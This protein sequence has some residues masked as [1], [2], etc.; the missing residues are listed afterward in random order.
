MTRLLQLYHRMPSFLRAAVASARGLQLQRYRY[1]P[2]LET[3]IAEAL[4]RETWDAASW[5]AWTEKHLRRLLVRAAT[6][7]PY[8]REQWARRRREGDTASWE[9][10]ANWPILPKRALKADQQSFLAD[11]R[12]PSRMDTIHTSGTTGT[13]LTMRASRESVRGWYTLIEAR[14]RRWYGV[15]KD[16]RWAMI[17]GQLVTPYRQTRPPFWV[18]NAGM[19]QLY[20]SSY[21]LSPERASAYLDALRKYRIV[22]I[23]GYASSL[24]SLAQFALEQ[25]LAAVPMKAAVSNAEPLLAYQR[26][27]IQA[28]FQCP[29]YDLYGMCERVCAASECPQGRMHL[30]PEVGHVEVVTDQADV[31][32]PDGEVGRLICTGLLNTDM[33]LIRYA[34]GDCG[35]LEPGDRSCACGR[36]LPM[37]KRI[38][39]RID[40]VLVTPDGRR[41]GRLDPV[42]KGDLPI[43]EAQ[44]IQEDRSRIRVRLVPSE[45]FSEATAG[46][47]LD[48]IRDRVGDMA[49]EIEIVDEIPR[50]ARGKFRAVINRMDRS[51]R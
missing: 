14:T 37:I 26:E 20:L 39:G 44:I 34:L 43:R 50:D 19:N 21:H 17:G 7:V 16:D 49:L 42:F 35:A 5:K 23:L 25:G 15:T 13:P 51:G 22:H 6:R 45:G 3:S 33:P 32:V 36:T 10:L 30:W 48:R 11:D 38:E 9:E 27:P 8:Y 2:N 31:P 4:A 47:V 24:Y 18:W 41:I 1:G 12:N 46:S 29:V 40:D 28:L